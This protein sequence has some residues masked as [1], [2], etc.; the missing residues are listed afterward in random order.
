MLILSPSQCRAARAW[1][2]IS[3]DELA[4]LAKVAK[5]TIALFEL[6]DRVPRDRTLD[7]I[8]RAFEVLGIT[9]S[10]DGPRAVGIIASADA[11]PAEKTRRKRTTAGSDDKQ[12][13]P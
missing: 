7:D 2:N 13:E 10:F 1:L 6:D 12:V 9:F 8:R 5:V 4:R 3:Q 11:R